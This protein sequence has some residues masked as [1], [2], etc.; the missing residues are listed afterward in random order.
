MT[1]KTQYNVKLNKFCDKSE[2]WHFALFAVYFTYNLN[3]L[4]LKL[5]FI[6]SN[7]HKVDND[8][9]CAFRRNMNVDGTIIGVILV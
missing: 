3:V 4:H 1:I 2:L 7:F 9:L 5:N 8:L 6:L